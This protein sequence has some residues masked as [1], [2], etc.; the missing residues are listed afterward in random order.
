[1]DVDKDQ[2]SIP[3]VLKGGDAGVVTTGTNR[4]G[5]NVYLFGGTPISGQSYGNVIVAHNG[6]SA[7]GNVGIGTTSPSQ[8]LEVSGNIRSPSGQISSSSFSISDGNVNFDSGNSGT[9]SL[10]CTNSSYDMNFAN[11]HDGGSYTLAVTGS[12]TAQ[13]N[14][15]GTLTG[16]GAGAVTYRTNFRKWDRVYHRHRDVGHQQLY[17]RCFKIN[18]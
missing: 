14:F 1:M 12:G 7:I 18:P 9:T 3:L 4:N 13:C 5:G 16:T 11:L 10:D 6:T 2:S 15:N 17:H 8:K